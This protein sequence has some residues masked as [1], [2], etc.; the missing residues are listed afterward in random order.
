MYDFLGVRYH[1]QRFVYRFQDTVSRRGKDCYFIHSSNNHELPPLR[2][3]GMRLITWMMEII[4]VAFCY[5]WWSICCFWLPP[6]TDPHCESLDEYI[7]RIL[8]PRN[9]VNFYLLPLLASVSTCSHKALLQFPARDL[10]EYKRRSAGGHHYTASSLN[11]V[12]Q[13]LG[14]GLDARFCATVINIEVL[15]DHRLKVMWNASEKIHEEIFDEVVLAVAPSIAGK[16]YQPLEHI[17]RQ[18]PTTTTQSVVQ[19]GPL[20]HAI[21]GTARGLP[22]EGT[23]AAQTIH[24]R[25]SARLGQTESIHVQESGAMVTTCPF[26]DLSSAQNVLKSVDIPR[27]LRTPRSRQIVNSIFGETVSLLDEK[28]LNWRNGDSGVWLVGG[29]CWDGMVLLEG[30]I[31]SAM[32]VASALNVEIPWRTLDI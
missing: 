4:Y 7:Q 31:V 26:D 1:S 11:E 25:T 23:R 6:T 18:I 10:T 21:N 8:L 20:R 12:Q 16:I 9:F 32:R 29:W 19:S 24:F 5:L 30:C 27:V 17:A 2:P 15:E 22:S 3:E 14:S 13:T 28:R